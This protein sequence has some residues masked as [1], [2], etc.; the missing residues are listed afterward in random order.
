MRKINYLVIHHSACMSTIPKLNLLNSFNNTHKE[1]LY[2]LYNQ[3]IAKCAYPH[4]AYHA[5]IFRDGEVVRV[6]PEET[7]GYHA[8]NLK[9]N[10][11]GIGICL[12]F[13]FNKESITPKAQ[14]ALGQLLKEYKRRFTLEENNIWFHRDFCRVD[15]K[16]TENMTNPSEH[17]FTKNCP[18]NNLT[19]EMIYQFLEDANIPNPIIEKEHIKTILD[20]PKYTQI[21]N[22][23]GR[24]YGFKK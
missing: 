18:G 7:I 11:E 19:R 10:N 2:K 8:S 13:D 22:R 3:P 24:L 16:T 5:I 6:R 23:N 9:A 17:P 14:K 21:E 4:I 12:A 20:I 1:R 15:K